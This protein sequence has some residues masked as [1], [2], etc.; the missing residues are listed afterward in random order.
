MV[1]QRGPR[2]PER[3]GRVRP[4]SWALLGLRGIPEV[5]NAGTCQTKA[6]WWVC[7]LKSQ[8]RARQGA[9]WAD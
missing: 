9:G 5:T 8:V 7:F 6:V 1:V 2:V 4:Q 3:A